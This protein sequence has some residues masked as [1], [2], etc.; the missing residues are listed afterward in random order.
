[1]PDTAVTFRP[2]TAPFVAYLRSAD[3][4]AALGLIDLGA[5]PDWTEIAAFTDG[6]R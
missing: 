1:M 6:A 5:D 2:T 4:P 3:P